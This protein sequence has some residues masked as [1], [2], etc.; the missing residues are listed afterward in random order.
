M[1]SE[2]NTPNDEQ[3]LAPGM[4][5]NSAGEVTIAPSVSETLFE[6]ALKLEDS[7]TLPVDVQHIVAAIA[8]AVQAGGWDSA[9]ELKADE[10]TADRLSE[11]VRIVFTQF[12][13]DI[14]EE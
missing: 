2:M 3:Q 5:M 11:Y 14:G 8:L 6:L 7:T 10:A 9:A 13:G 4:V 12:D 1:R